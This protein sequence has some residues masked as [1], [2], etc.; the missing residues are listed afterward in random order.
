MAITDYITLKSTLADYL[1]RS[2]LSDSILSNF[3]Q[4]GEARINR[5]LRL[6]QQEEIAT[7]T[8]AAG[9]STVA[10]PTNW[11][12]TIDVVYAD[13]KRSLQPQNIRA[14]NSQ[15]SSAN[16]TGRPLLYA[17]TNGTLSFEITADIQYSILLNYFERWNI[18]ADTTNWLLENAPDAYLYASL[19]EAKAYTKKPQELSLWADGLQTALDDLNQL[20]NRS[21]RNATSRIDNALANGRRFDINIGY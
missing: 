11:Q 13:N 4:L 17:V 6:L 15:S 8:L 1:H 20:D 18:A 9:D 3:V 12:E 2:D 14:L 7:L 10:L 19:I 21:R 16:A 5:Q